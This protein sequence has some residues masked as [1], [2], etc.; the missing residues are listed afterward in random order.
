MACTGYDTAPVLLRE[1][2]ATIT[3][4]LRSPHPRHVAWARLVA[5]GLCVQLNEPPTAIPVQS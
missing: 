5:L 3:I 4:P 2:G 1:D